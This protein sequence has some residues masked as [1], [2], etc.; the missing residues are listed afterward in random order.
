[1]SIGGV[2]IRL[3]H[4]VAMPGFATPGYPVRYDIRRTALSAAL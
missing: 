2:G 1:V 4:F 3:V